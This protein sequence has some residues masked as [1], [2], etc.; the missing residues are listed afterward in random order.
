MLAGRLV[1]KLDVGE[2]DCLA[3]CPRH[4][5]VIFLTDDL[6]ARRE[7]QRLGFAVHGSVGVIVRAFRVGLLTRPE[8]DAQLVALRDCRSLFVS[9][10]IIDL[11]RGQL[12]ASPPA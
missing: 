5:G 8:A 6:A 4:P 1:A 2:L 7:A 12:A 11:A 10:A 9:K 3:L